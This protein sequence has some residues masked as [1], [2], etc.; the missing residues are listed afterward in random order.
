MTLKRII[1]GF[2]T[3]NEGAALVTVLLLVSFMSAGAVVA[4]DA[5]ASSVARTTHGRLHDQ[6]RL[7]A[8][9]GEALAQDAAQNMYTSNALVQGSQDGAALQTVAYPIDG[10]LITGQLKDAS[11]CFN[12]NS[13]VEFVRDGLV[14]KQDEGAARYARLL[15]TLGIPEG[16]S[17]A[18]TATLVDWLDSDSRPNRQ[19]AEDYA[20]ALKVPAYRTANSLMAD[21]TELR[22]VKGYTPE[23][24]ARISHMLCARPDTEPAQLNVNA[25]ETKHAPLLIAAFGRELGL[26]QAEQLIAER[27]SAGYRD[28]ASFWREPAFNG[29]GIAANADQLAA[30]KPQ[31]L[32]A[33]IKVDLYEASVHMRSVFLM[34]TSGRAQVIRRE[35]GASL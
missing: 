18:L 23:L 16:K 25:L 22:L 9:G 28:L 6:A 2:F 20:Y 17:V 15:N 1:S 5:L 21:V 12:I 35:F 10:G 13:V 33:D 34:S 27:P 4:F 31:A 14:V 29:I 26:A 32:A 24:L 3:A 11:N 8:L 19:G 7:F 30:V